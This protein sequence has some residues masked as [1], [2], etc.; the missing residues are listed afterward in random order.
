MGTAEVVDDIQ[1]DQINT[2]GLVS[3]YQ[4]LDGSAQRIAAHNPSITNPEGNWIGV[5]SIPYLEK[6]REKKSEERPTRTNLSTETRNFIEV[7]PLT[8]HK[9]V[10]RRYEGLDLTFYKQVMEVHAYK[11]FIEFVGK[12][13]VEMFEDD[14]NVYYTE[15]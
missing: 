12:L 4:V 5:V 9:D 6:L 7:D 3:A 8:K 14:F 15:E 11:I 2:K 10:Y 13:N 1:L